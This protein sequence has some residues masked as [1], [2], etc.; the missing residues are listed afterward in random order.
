M[1]NTF[2][3]LAISAL[4]AACASTPSAPL[5]DKPAEKPAAITAGTPLVIDY[6]DN[7]TLSNKGAIAE[8]AYSQNAGDTR[9]DPLLL[10]DGALTVSGQVGMGKGSSWAGIGVQL[11][12]GPD[13]LEMNATSYKSVTFNLAS[14]TTGTLRLRLLG[15]DE[16][17]KNAGCYPIVMQPVSGTMS[18]VT[19]EL[20]KFASEGWC[21]ANA[22]T[23]K[24]TMRFFTG[25]EIVDVA[26]QK[27]PTSF[28]IGKI[29][30]NP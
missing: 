29:T 6:A 16:A 10:T 27:K 4:A 30:L 20:A 23:V 22:R 8:I 13:K 26:I 1:R 14:A 19:I 18:S 21:G 2:T 11:P 17:I 9:F 15:G 12:I 24:D 28:A 7:K 5:T 3:C 25:Y